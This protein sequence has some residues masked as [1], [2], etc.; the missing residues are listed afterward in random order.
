MLLWHYLFNL[1][2]VKGKYQHEAKAA[3]HATP[4]ITTCRDICIWISKFIPH[5]MMDVITWSK[6]ILFT[7]GEKYFDYISSYCL[8]NHLFVLVFKSIHFN[9]TWSVRWSTPS[10]N[11]Y[12]DNE[13]EY[14]NYSLSTHAMVIFTQNDTQNL[15]KIINTCGDI[16]VKILCWN[17]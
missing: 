14:D 16:F 7:I 4:A 17:W 6:H 12:S 2:N 15:T 11:T 5:Q 13:A 8:C 3:S 9:N 10:D 1:V